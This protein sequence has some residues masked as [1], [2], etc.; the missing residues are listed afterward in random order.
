M[1]GNEIVAHSEGCWFYHSTLLGEKE[2]AERIAEAIFKVEA[3]AEQ[4][5][6]EFA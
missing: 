6:K 4:L 5:A 1:P 2:N 3:N